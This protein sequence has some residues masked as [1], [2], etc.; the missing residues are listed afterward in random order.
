MTPFVPIG[1]V[2]DIGN[3]CVTAFKLPTAACGVN[4]L[5][6]AVNYK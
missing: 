3:W 4:K 1:I 2:S 6:F 5:E